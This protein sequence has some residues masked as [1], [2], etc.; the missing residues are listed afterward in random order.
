MQATDQNACIEGPTG[1]CTGAK[2]MTML[3]IR[4]LPVA[5]L[6]SLRARAAR[7]G[8]SKEAEVRE[9][10]AAAVSPASQVKLGSLLAEIGRQAQM[11]NDEFAAFEQVRRMASARLTTFE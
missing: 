8:R 11:T 2:T 10:L 4:N 5:V 3:P 7:H 6:Q 1:S 9:I